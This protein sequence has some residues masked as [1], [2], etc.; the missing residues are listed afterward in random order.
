MTHCAR[1]HFAEFL[2]QPGRKKATS[3]EEGTFCSSAALQVDV[4]QWNVDLDAQV[5]SASLCF[6]WNRF[7][8]R[9]SLGLNSAGLTLMETLHLCSF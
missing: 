8:P 2:S 6:Q 5:D 9:A 4:A 3:E 7:L 1:W